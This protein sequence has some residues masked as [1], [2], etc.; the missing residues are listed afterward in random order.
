M[1]PGRGV[2]PLMDYT[3]RV[4]VYKREGISRVEE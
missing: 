4:E 2:L 1:V 3:G